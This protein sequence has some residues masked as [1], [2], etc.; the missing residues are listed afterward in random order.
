MN[1]LTE[2]ERLINNIL[3]FNSNGNLQTIMLASSADGEGTSTVVSNL[4][5]TL[6][7]NRTFKVC[8]IDGNFRHPTLKELYGIKNSKGLSDFL[9]NRADIKD[10]MRQ[11][12]IPKLWIIPG[13]E[14]VGNSLGEFDFRKLKELTNRL[15]E[16]FNYIIFDSASIIPYPDTHSLFSMVDGVILVVHAGKTRWEIV[17]RAKE[18]LEMSHANILGV[19]LNRR[20]FIIP[21]FFYNRL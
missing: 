2:F 5:N 21:K 12:T 19:I 13:G 6:A 10:V 8:L 20:E 17:R 9:L 1:E 4:A 14:N 11:T 18:H 15:K 7:K 16:A 3:S